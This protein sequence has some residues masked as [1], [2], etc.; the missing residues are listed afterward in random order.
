VKFGAE[1]DPKLLSVSRMQYCSKLA[2]TNM[3]TV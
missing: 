2:I 1:M 3:V